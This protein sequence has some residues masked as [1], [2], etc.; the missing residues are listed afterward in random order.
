MNDN[1][2]AARLRLVDVVWTPTGRY[3]NQVLAVGETSVTIVS[4]VTGNE[5]VIPFQHIREWRTTNGCII[6]SFRILL[7]LESA[8]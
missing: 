8:V 2:I 7:G 1:E 4:E 6:R 5:R 3:R